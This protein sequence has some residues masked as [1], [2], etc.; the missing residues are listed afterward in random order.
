M[1]PSRESLNKIS[2]KN[3]LKDGSVPD[4]LLY[5]VAG[6]SRNQDQDFLSDID[7]VW[8]G[9]RICPEPFAMFLIDSGNSSC[10]SLTRYADLRLRGFNIPS[11]VVV[12]KGKHKAV[13]QYFQSPWV[14]SLLDN[15]PGLRYVGDGKVWKNDFFYLKFHI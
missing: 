8:L 12:P 15:I 3:F 4:H 1:K 5:D 7:L 14:Q 6:T 10:P 11:F 13:K 9:R 2:N